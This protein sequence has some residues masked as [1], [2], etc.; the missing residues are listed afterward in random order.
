LVGADFIE[1]DA[2]LVFEFRQF[3]VGVLVFRLH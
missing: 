3:C 1:F 2:D